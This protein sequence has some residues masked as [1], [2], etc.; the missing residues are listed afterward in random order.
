SSLTFNTFPVEKSQFMKRGGARQSA[1]PQN[2]K[3][4]PQSHSGGLKTS[5][6]FI[7]AGHTAKIDDKCHVL[8]S[9]ERRKVDRTL[10]ELTWSNKLGVLKQPLLNGMSQYKARCSDMDW[11]HDWRAY[12]KTGYLREK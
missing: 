10:A 8:S 7:L 6:T 2:S 3:L 5:L 11:V 1:C 12:A 4:L 9:D